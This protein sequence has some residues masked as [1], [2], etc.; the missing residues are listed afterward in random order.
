MLCLETDEIQQLAK[1]VLESLKPE[2]L[3]IIEGTFILD[4]F[5]ADFFSA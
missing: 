1:D 2:L 4:F 5:G 3:S